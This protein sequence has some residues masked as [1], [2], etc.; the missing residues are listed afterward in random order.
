MKLENVAFIGLVVVGKLQAKEVCPLKSIIRH[1]PLM[2]MDGY[3][4]GKTEAFLPDLC[5]RD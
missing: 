2:G 4:V 5:E 3:G 1:D